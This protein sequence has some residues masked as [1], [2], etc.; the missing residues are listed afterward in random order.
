MWIDLTVIAIPDNNV[1]P[2]LHLDQSGVLRTVRML[3]RVNSSPS[4]TTTHASSPRQPRCIL[5]TASST[6]WISVGEL[7]M[8]QKFHSSLFA[9]PVTPLSSWNSRTFSM[10]ITA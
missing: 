5:A 9:A 2:R 10:A 8:T 3:R 4:T 6:G 1:T 7:A